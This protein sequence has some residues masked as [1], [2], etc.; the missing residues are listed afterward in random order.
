[1]AQNRGGA[2][3]ALKIY[4]D[5]KEN[6]E[7]I[8]MKDLKINGAVLKELGITDGRTI[9]EALKCALDAVH[10]DN[11]NNNKEYLEKF[12]LSRFAL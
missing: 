6:K 3:E 10:R 7:C 12:V 8:Y 1:M 2:D 4:N 5:I 9:G 11:G